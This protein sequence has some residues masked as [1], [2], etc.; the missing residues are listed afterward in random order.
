MKAKSKRSRIRVSSSGFK[1]QLSLLPGHLIVG[2]WCLLTLVMLF[3]IVAASLSTAPEIMRGETL[4][5]A[6]GLHFENYI[7]AWSTNS[8]STFFKNS[9]LY[10]ICAMAGSVLVSAPAA[11]VLARCFFKGNTVIR[12]GFVTAM[13]I[14]QIMVVL[15][16]FSLAT[17]AHLTGSKIVLILLYIGMQVPYTTTFLITFFASLSRVYE[18]AAAI[19]GCPPMK[20]FWKIMLP[21]AQPGIVTVCIFNFMNVWNEYFLS[22]IFASSEK[23]M[24]VGPGLKSVLTA[25]QY[26]GD[27][28]GLFAAVVIVF[29]PTLLLFLI[30][31]RTIIGGITSGG[32][33][34]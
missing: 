32:V 29:L 3:W 13:S 8:I 30:L 15:P 33:K 27:W 23:N 18:E 22:L 7:R 34:G 10:G 1:K 26:T 24:P 4:K 19:D 21:L 11:Y 17:R 28:G 5:F 31:S 6:T 20:T 9:L 2:L 25:M 12:S 14:P 16:L